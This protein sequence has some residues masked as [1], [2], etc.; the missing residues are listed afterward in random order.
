MKTPIT[1]E[2]LAEK[3]NGRPIGQ[4][5]EPGERDQADDAGLVVVFGYADCVYLRGAIHDGI[6]LNPPF[7]IFSFRVT[8]EGVAPEWNGEFEERTKSEAEKFFRMNAMPCAV[9]TALWNSEGKCAC[10]FETDL[11]HA[12]FDLLEDGA[13][14]RGIVFSLGDLPK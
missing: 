11:P 14:C 1:K 4:E 12:T 5:I 9:I 13:F 7:N 8:S 6:P 10:T 3:I 2:Q